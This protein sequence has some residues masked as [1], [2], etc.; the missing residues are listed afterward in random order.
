[1][2]SLTKEESSMRL[3]ETSATLSSIFIAAMSYT[4]ISMCANGLNATYCKVGAQLIEIHLIS[5][6]G[7]L[8]TS[9]FSKFSKTATDAFPLLL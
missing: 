5:S 3:E 8:S 6:E 1:M 7:V 9:G 4:P 2:F